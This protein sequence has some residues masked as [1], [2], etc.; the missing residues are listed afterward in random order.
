MKRNHLNLELLATGT[1]PAPVL[2]RCGTTG[3]KL[4]AFL[5][6][7][8]GTGSIESEAPQVVT[9]WKSDALQFGFTNDSGVELKQGREVILKTTGLLDKRSAGSEIPL[10]VVVIGGIDGARCTVRTGFTAAI[11]A[12][13]IGG[14]LNAG[15][16]V[17][18][19]GNVDSDGIPEYIAAVAK[20]YA[21]GYVIKG[22]AANASIK[23]GILDTAVTVRV[24]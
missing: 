4:F 6:D 1:I 18:P 10:G 23:V 2:R 11:K 3:R 24:P 12:K 19:N 20:D 21:T 16:Y 22:G 7:P 17:V 13:A 15:T 14:T 9:D 5:T 8:T